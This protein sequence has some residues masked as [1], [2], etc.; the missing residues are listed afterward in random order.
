MWQKESD[1]P[2]LPLEL[3]FQ[4]MTQNV[5]LTTVS[6]KSQSDGL[7]LF[8]ESSPE[9]AVEVMTVKK[10]SMAGGREIATGLKR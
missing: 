7:E 3:A 10:K 6:W 9:T 8:C 4:A 2:A 5:G 1:S